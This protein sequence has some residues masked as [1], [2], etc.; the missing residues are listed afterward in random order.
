MSARV[1]DNRFILTV[2]INGEDVSWEQLA[3]DKINIIESCRDKYPTGEFSFACTAYYV[4]A[5]PPVDGSTVYI[6]LLDTQAPTPSPSFYKM[7]VFNSKM[8]SGAQHFRY[9][10]SLRIDAP[11]L[12]NTKIKSYGKV[13]S[14]QA[15][16]ACAGDAGLSA[17][18]DSTADVQYWLRTNEKGIDFITKTSEHSW[19]SNNSCFVTCIMADGTLRHWDVNSRSGGGAQWRMINRPSPPFVPAGND[20]LFD[21]IDAEFCTI[22]GSLNSIA[23][24]G[25]DYGSYNLDS[26]FKSPN[27]GDT[28]GGGGGGVVGNILNAAQSM[29]GSQRADTL[30]YES[31]NTHPHYNQ[32]AIQNLLYK[33]QYSTQPEINCRYP[34]SALLLD[35]VDLQPYALGLGDQVIGPW[36]GTYFVSH[37]STLITP[38]E[39]QKKYTLIRKGMAF[40]KG[41]GLGLVG[42]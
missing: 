8:W 27:A 12:F 41:M 35:L 25:A 21:S 6:T 17:Q 26:G 30:P 13:S 9:N 1:L 7:R 2:V 10:L 18:C 40:E 28:G 42:G 11:D 22:S 38:T 20:I 31:D 39:V 37:I 23:G 29:I 16:A 24:Y 19:A 4:L 15:I 32:A 36:A 33:A 14:A 5:N 3:L 34:K